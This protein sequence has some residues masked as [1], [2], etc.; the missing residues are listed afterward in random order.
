M[1][2]KFVAGEPAAVLDD[3]LVIGDV[4]L[5]IEYELQRK[6]Y[7][8][9]LQ[10]RKVAE[11]LNGLLKQTKADT[12]IFLGDLKH[13]VY[14]MRD[15]EERMLNAFFRLLKA[16][17]IIVCK[18][19]HDPYIENCKGIQV[20]PPEGILY[21]DTETLLLHGHALPDSKLLKAAK[22][23][24]FGHE[25]PLVRM[26]DGKHAWT[27]KVWII[28]QQK[29]KK[30]VIFPHFCDLVGGREFDPEH[31]LVRFLTKDACRKADAYLLSGLKLGKISRI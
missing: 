20:A 10:Y 19:N 21:E 4:H 2:L 16:K 25:H 12:V 11:R 1:E 7:N 29:G 31:H 27:E 13:D 5:G 30:F 8:I 18:G 3:A 26:E 6:G 23:I 15:Q 17:R 9:A 28:G 24:C 22:T 14:G